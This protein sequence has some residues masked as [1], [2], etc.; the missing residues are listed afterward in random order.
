MIIGL[1]IV[2]LIVGAHIWRLRQFEI[3]KNNA[4]DA[5]W[6]EEHTMD[7]VQEEDYNGNDLHIREEERA[8]WNGLTRKQKRWIM[9]EQKK[10]LKSGQYVKTEDGRLITRAEAKKHGLI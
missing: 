6:E 9:N 3:K 10:K 8:M 1:L 4:I 7:E 5:M 2:A